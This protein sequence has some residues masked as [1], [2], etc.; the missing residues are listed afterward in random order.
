M[1]SEPINNTMI[2]SQSLQRCSHQH[3]HSL[4]LLSYSSIP[5]PD[6]PQKLSDFPNS[7]SSG[8]LGE[9]HKT[10]MITLITNLGAPI[11]AL[12]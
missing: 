7:E 1:S 10:M 6:N 9:N 3:L 12:L 11:S 8:T 5:S 2:P 4:A